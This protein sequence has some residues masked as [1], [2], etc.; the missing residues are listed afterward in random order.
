VFY[1][2]ERAWSHAMEKKTSGT[3]A[4]TVYLHVGS[5]SKSS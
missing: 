4:K 5:I 3:N 2:A 1:M